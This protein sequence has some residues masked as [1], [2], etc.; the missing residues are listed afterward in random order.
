M[1]KFNTSDE[2]DKLLLSY[3]NIDEKI[4]IKYEKDDDE[5]NTLYQKNITCEYK[6]KSITEMGTGVLILIIIAGVFG[7]I[8]IGVIIWKIIDNNKM[9]K[10]KERKNES[11]MELAHADIKKEGEDRDEK[12]SLLK[13]V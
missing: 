4:P 5:I 10:Y 11:L 6:R 13:E 3:Y 1:L 7:L 9:N 8:V 2:E 12:T